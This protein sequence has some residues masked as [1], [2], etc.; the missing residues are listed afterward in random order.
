MC[1]GP[2]ADGVAMY[3]GNQGKGLWS[4]VS[5]DRKQVEVGRATTT[6][7]LIGRVMGL[8]LTLKKPSDRGVGQFIWGMSPHLPGS[9]LHP[10]ILGHRKRTGGR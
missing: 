1:S 2:R 5:R 7:R 3:S 8:G 6:R 10:S 4:S 9:L